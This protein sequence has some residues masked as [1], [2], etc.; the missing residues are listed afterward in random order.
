MTGRT[1]LD[2]L[3]VG[4]VVK[5]RRCL[6][7][8]GGPV[9]A[10][11]IAGLLACGASV[12]VVAPELHEAV[13]A[14]ARE[15]ALEDIDEHP[16]DLQ[17]RPYRSG[18]A[19]AYCLVFTAT[20]DPVV[21]AEVSADADAAKV[22]VN[23]ADDPGHCSAVLPAVHRDGAVS[24]AVSTGGSSPALASW[25]RDRVARALGPGLG[26]LAELLAEGRATLVSEGRATSELD[27]RELLDGPLPRLVAE[28]KL[29]EARTLLVHAI[30]ILLQ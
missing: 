11:K 8:G 17:L 30:D 24:V 13:A 5:G 9:A 12:T 14:L 4:L 28:G 2:V 29:A 23:S 6:V 3:P 19:A 27:W 20:G 15:G 18:E 26:E 16:L 7:V 22:W 25:L 21:D 10:R 1:G